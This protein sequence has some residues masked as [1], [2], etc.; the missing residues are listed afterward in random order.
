MAAKV[1]LGMERLG[2]LRSPDML[3][4]AMMPVT[5]GKKRAKT[6]KKEKSGVQAGARLARRMSGEKPRP[7]PTKNER[8]DSRRTAR[9][10]YWSR[11][12]HPA[13]I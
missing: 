6:A 5:A 4:P 9:M 1:P 10:P 11:M 8:M 12:V 2:S 7:A 13:P 3:T